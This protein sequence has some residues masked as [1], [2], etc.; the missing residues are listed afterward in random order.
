MRARA[1]AAALAALLLALACGDGDRGPARIAFGRDACSHCGMAISERRFAV[2]VRRGRDVARFD[3]FGC[4][5]LWLERHGAQPDEIWA[6]DSDAAGERV[7]WLD[8][9]RAAF[10]PRQRTPMAYGFAAVAA[11]RPGDLDFESAR[12]AILEH[13]RERAD[14]RDAR[15]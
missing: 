10:R 13:E 15:R 11:A 14:G 5:V 1:L 3:D 7:E 6:A 8:A 4:A 9:R 2:Q 12:R